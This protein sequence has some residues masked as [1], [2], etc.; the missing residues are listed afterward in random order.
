MFVSIFACST[1]GVVL[2][3]I[4]ITIGDFFCHCGKQFGYKRNLV[5]HQKHACGK[6]PG[7]QCPLCSY[8]THWKN[9]LRIHM[10]KRHEATL[11][12]S[13]SAGGF[14]GK[15]L[16]KYK[17]HRCECGS[18]FEHLSR[19]KYHKRAECSQQLLCPVCPK[20]FKHKGSLKRHLLTVHKSFLKQ[21]EAWRETSSNFWVRFPEIKNQLKSPHIEKLFL[22]IADVTIIPTV[23]KFVEDP[24]HII[25]KRI[26]RKT[27]IDKSD[28]K[29]K[30]R[31][32]ECGFKC[33]RTYEYNYHVTNECG[34]DLRCP[35]CQQRF[36]RVTSIKRHLKVAHHK[37][38]EELGVLMAGFSK[39]KRRST[40]TH[41]APTRCDCP[42]C[43]AGEDGNKNSSGEW[44]ASPID[45]R[46]M[47]MTSAKGAKLME[48]K[49][50][51]KVAQFKVPFRR[52][53]SGLHKCVC[54]ETYLRRDYLFRHMKSSCEL[55]R[56]K[57]RKVTEDDGSAINPFGAYYEKKFK[58]D[59]GKKYYHPHNLVRHKK[60][61]CRL[62]KG[63][64]IEKKTQHR[65]HGECSG[66]NDA[67][68]KQDGVDDRS[69]ASTSGSYVP[70]D[71]LTPEVSLQLVES[72]DEF[73]VAQTE[74]SYEDLPDIDMENMD[75]LIEPQVEAGIPQ[76]KCA[77][78]KSFSNGK[79]LGGHSRACR[80]RL[81]GGAAYKCHCG[82]KFPT[83]KRLV[84]HMSQRHQKS[85]MGH[86][87][88]EMTDLSKKIKVPKTDKEKIPVEKPF[89]CVCGKSYANE[90][91]LTRHIKNNCGLDLRCPLCGKNHPFK[92]R[93]YFHMRDVHGLRPETVY[94][95]RPQ[96]EVT[97]HPS[98]PA[99]AT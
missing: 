29:K 36:F 56:A 18:G 89:D 90:F 66:A 68:M 87:N 13:W 55:A 45:G 17:P 37:D 15:R 88:I 39:P 1:Q 97:D 99:S 23:R 77:C 40:R 92:A 51:K 85:P 12:G 32:C 38:K 69:F 78:G 25:R 91:L 21:K 82:L 84:R 11:E 3:W 49:Y 34:R 20:I 31:V 95:F 74:D 48:M 42:D 30:V 65:Q 4:F 53:K 35:I 54:G 63:G 9:Q 72:L 46:F 60:T 64:N 52:I 14:Q 75:D 94:P 67:A 59:C 6:P 43:N 44:K 50:K 96:D 28:P 27:Y 5:A 26:L 10:F 19:L 61:S 62:L 8:A 80:K 58:C 71:A 73:G 33:T 57:M 81:L 70:Y 83:K 16:S 2:N 86:L 98:L 7:H 24:A 93:L 79:Q 22:I 76:Y 47:E 41:R